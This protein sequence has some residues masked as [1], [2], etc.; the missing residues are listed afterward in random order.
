MMCAKK[1]TYSPNTRKLSGHARHDRAWWRIEAR[2][3]GLLRLHA[4]V[5]ATWRARHDPDYERAAA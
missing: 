2:R 4:E 5:V 3:P 1:I